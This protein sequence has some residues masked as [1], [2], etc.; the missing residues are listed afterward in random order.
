MNFFNANLQISLYKRSNASSCKQG[1]AYI[2]MA[3]KPY[4]GYLFIIKRCF[5]KTTLTANASCEKQY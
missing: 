1:C 5:Q 3:T 2:E 4:I